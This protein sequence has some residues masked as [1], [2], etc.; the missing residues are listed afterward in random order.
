[1][2]LPQLSV[3]DLFWLVLVAALLCGWWVAPSNRGTTLFVALAVVGLGV[4]WA[5]IRATGYWG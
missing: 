1:M 5:T 3:R 4:A 2:K